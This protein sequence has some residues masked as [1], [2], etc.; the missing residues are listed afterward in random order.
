MK[1]TIEKDDDTTEVFQ[2]ISDLYIAFRQRDIKYEK[3]SKR[4]LENATV[5]SFSWGTNVRELIKELQQ[6]LVEL[7]D[8]LRRTR[9]GGSA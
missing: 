8:F 2:N 6:S 7:Q 5:R 4:L 3:E 9:D 1:I